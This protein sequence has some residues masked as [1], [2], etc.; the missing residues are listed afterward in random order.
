[1]SDGINRLRDR[2]KDLEDRLHERDLAVATLAQQLSERDA[3]WK[4]AIQ[5]L[6]EQGV[7]T[8]DDP[9]AAIQERMEAEGGES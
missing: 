8:I 5:S 3:A 4:Q 9:L 1:M 6:A 2:V 7:I